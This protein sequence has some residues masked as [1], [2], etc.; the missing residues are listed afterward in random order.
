MDTVLTLKSGEQFAG[1][2]SGAT[3]QNNEPRY[4]LKM[5]RQLSQPASQQSNGT[6]PVQG[7]LVGEG[8]DHAMAFDVNDTVDLSVQRVHIGTAQNRAVN[9]KEKQ[10][11]LDQKSCTNTNRLQVQDRRRDLWQS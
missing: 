7:L 5:V 4:H 10:E 11:Q 2:F 1:V 6:T 3:S 9:G 8:E